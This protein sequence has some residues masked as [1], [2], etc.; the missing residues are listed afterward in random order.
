M[1]D[2]VRRV[3]VEGLATDNYVD[4]ANQVSGER[5]SLVE[6]QVVS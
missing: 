4:L 6:A 2:Q 1:D 5:R 3:V